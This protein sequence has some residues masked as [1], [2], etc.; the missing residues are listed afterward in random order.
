MEDEAPRWFV[1]R[2]TAGA[3]AR[4]AS[5]E[6]QAKAHWTAAAY[7]HWRVRTLPG[8][9][10]QRVGDSVE[11]RYHYYAAGQVA[12]A[13]EGT[14]WVCSQLHIWGAWEWEER[15]LRETLTWLPECSQETA[16]FL[17]DLGVV[18][19]ARG[20]YTQALDWY[21]Q[22]LAIAEA[23]G[24][25]ATMAGSYHHLGWIAQERGDDDQ[26]RVHYWGTDSR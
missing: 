11:A 22:S 20:D 5:E 23:L 4:R 14:K 24:D 21:R 13:I 25:R 6:E 9:S 10:E 17:H 1:H 16:L 2:W 15:L 7:W 19:Q 3:L 12:K 18:A 26:A 8:S